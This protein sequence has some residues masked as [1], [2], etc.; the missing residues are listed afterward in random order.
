MLV[1][2]DISNILVLVFFGY[3]DLLVVESIFRWTR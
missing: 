2:I 3:Q 1:K